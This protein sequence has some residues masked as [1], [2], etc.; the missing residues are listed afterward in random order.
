MDLEDTWKRHE[1][2]DQLHYQDKYRTFNN[3]WQIFGTALVYL[4]QLLRFQCNNL[5]SQAKPTSTIW[6]RKISKFM[7]TANYHPTLI[8][9]QL[10]PTFKMAFELWI[11]IFEHLECELPQNLFLALPWAKVRKSQFS[12]LPKINET[13]LFEIFFSLYPQKNFLA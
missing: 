10:M 12:K 3:I 4:E 11:H 8:S 2:L 13:I 7:G 6:R 9:S 5:P 1:Y